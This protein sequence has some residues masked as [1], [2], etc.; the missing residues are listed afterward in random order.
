MSI[1]LIRGEDQ[2]RCRIDSHLI[3]VYIVNVASCQRLIDRYVGWSLLTL[4]PIY[5]GII[6]DL[7]ISESVEIRQ[8][9][10]L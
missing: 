1:I 8:I 7:E 4:G 3:M 6:W 10:G 5:F 9:S 2:V